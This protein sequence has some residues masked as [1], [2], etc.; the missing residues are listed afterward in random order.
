MWMIDPEKDFL[1]AMLEHDMLD[2]G[3]YR[4]RKLMLEVLVAWAEGEISGCQ[5]CALTGLDLVT[6]RG[7]KNSIVDQVKERWRVWREA[8]PP[9]LPE[10]TQ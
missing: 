1:A 4:Q 9:K 8:N 7:W 6:L 3:S 2:A 5:A 10:V